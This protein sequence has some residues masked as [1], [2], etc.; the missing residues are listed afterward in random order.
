MVP[1]EEFMRHAAECASMAKSSRDPASKAVW[2]RM[3]KRWIRC[4]ELARPLDPPQSSQRK[5][6][7]PHA[8]PHHHA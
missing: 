7:K 5:P 6:G 8:A 2:D 1:S 4:A 3:A